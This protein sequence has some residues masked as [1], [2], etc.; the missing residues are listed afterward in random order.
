MSG[1]NNGPYVPPQGSKFDCKTSQIKT[2]IS[3]IDLLIL[4]NLRVGEILEVQVVDK[5]ILIY[6]ANGE[7]VGVI[8]H[9][10]TLDLMKCIKDG[11]EY[12]ATIIGIQA[13]QCTILIK[14]QDL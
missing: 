6:N 10:N 9:P 12:K 1:S 8:I 13:P 14:R 7:F 3:S 11:N 4:A 2:N 5:K